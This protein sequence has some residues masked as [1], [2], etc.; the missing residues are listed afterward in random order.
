MRA[1]AYYL[2]RHTDSKASEGAILE[3]RDI[4]EAWAASHPDYKVINDFTENETD[5]GPRH[6]L[7]SAIFRV[8]K[9]RVHWGRLPTA[10]VP[11]YDFQRL[12]H[13]GNDASSNEVNWKGFSPIQ[14]FNVDLDAS[15]ANNQ[16]PMCHPPD[17]ETMS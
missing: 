10:N 4:V 16:R 2:T 15:G 6:I 1:I 7:R 9:A 3:Q 13:L 11:S 12:S 8:V 17:F 5:F 14:L